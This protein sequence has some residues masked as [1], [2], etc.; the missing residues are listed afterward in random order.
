MS[1]ATVH[2]SAPTIRVRLQHSNTIK[3]GWRLSETTVE[4]TGQGDPDWIGISHALIHAGDVGREHARSMNE[5][6]DA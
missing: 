4:W 3:E 5:T 6:G 1:D 2:Q